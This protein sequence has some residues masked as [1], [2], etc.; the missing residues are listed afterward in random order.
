[1]LPIVCF[2]Q[3]SPLERLNLVVTQWRLQYHYSCLLWEYFLNTSLLTVQYNSISIQADFDL[4]TYSNRYCCQPYS[5]RSSRQG[6]PLDWCSPVTAV[7]PQD[8]LPWI[9]PPHHQVGMKPRKAHRHHWR[10]QE[11]WRNM[12]GEKSQHIL[13]IWTSKHRG[14]RRE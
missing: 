4:R 1:M 6:S 8:N 14:R 10:L 13:C 9:G 2:G 12:E 3:L 5:V 11:R 7:V